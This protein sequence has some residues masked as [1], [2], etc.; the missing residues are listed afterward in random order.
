MIPL[1]EGISGSSV[2]FLK[3]SPPTH[4]QTN[5]SSYL[6]LYLIKNGDRIVSKVGCSS[7]HK[8]QKENAEF[9]I[10]SQAS[11][12][13]SGEILFFGIILHSD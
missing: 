3:Q 10:K 5:V 1:V 4:R 13:T 9:H 8:R 11:N 6:L 7:I 12:L 2:L